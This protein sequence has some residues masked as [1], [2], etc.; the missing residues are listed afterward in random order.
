METL[1]PEQQ[2]QQDAKGDVQRP[3][4]PSS[5]PLQ[6]TILTEFVKIMTKLMESIE[7]L[8]KLIMPLFILIAILVILV[9]GYSLIVKNSSQNGVGNQ[10]SLSPTPTLASV[11]PS[12]SWRIYKNNKLRLQ[13]SVPP[14]VRVETKEGDAGVSFKKNDPNL[15]PYLYVIDI[16][17][18]NTLTLSDPVDNHIANLKLMVMGED[19]NI[20][21]RKLKFAGNDAVAFES[22]CGS[23]CKELFVRYDAKTVVR[24]S[25]RFA[26][27]EQ[28]NNPEV[29]QIMSTFKFIEPETSRDTGDWLTYT[30]SQIGFSF[31]YPPE[32]NET[33]PEAPS[34]FYIGKPLAVLRTL[35]SEYHAPNWRQES[36]FVIS[37]EK[38]RNKKTQCFL[39]DTGA[40]MQNSRSINDNVF[41]EDRRTGVATGSSS[42]SFLYRIMRNDNC[43]E[44]ALTVYIVSDFN[45]IDFGAAAKSQVSVKNLLDQMLATFKFI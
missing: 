6:V 27:R 18:I 26:G 23:W 40:E 35:R 5:K 3:G 28:A 43:I 29:D 13:L 17:K 12:A 16:T 41:F 11:N 20:I 15:S 9:V 44:I 25:S 2:L 34:H 36:L 24:I 45:G 32:F 38:D 22:E 1:L 7:S 8:K 19:K 4:V 31:R 42:E 14:Q 33:E 30:D 37:I 39:G 21:T 10:I